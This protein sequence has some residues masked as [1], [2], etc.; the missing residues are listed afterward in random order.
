MKSF[1]LKLYPDTIGTGGPKP[2]PPPRATHYSQ[3]R[4]TVQVSPHHRTSG[5]EYVLTADC[6]LVFIRKTST[7]V[8]NFTDLLID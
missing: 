7:G 1:P 4:V 6:Q 3:V 5:L 8:P 2:P